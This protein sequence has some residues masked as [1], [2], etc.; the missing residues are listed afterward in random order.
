MKYL[1]YIFSLSTL[2]ASCEQGD[3]IEDKKAALVEKQQALATLEMEIS[4]LKQELA[5]EN[6]PPPKARK[7]VTVLQAVKQNFNRFITIQGNIEPNEIAI[8]TP[9][10]PGRIVS[11]AVNEGDYVQKGSLIA[12]IDMEQVEKQIAEIENSLRFAKD[13]YNRQ[14]RLWD[15]QIGSE[16][17]FLQ[18]KNQVESLEKSLESVRFQQT[19]A[20]VYAPISGYIDMV[21]QKPGELASPGM[22]IVQILDSRQVKIVAEVP[23]RYIGKV[24]RGD[25]LHVRFPAL[26]STLK[27]RV[28]LVGKTIN[29]N[30]RS[31]K[32]E[33]KLTNPNGT[34]K[35]NLMAEVLISD[36]EAKD[37]VV[38]PLELVQQEVGGK[39]YVMTVVTEG[40]DG[41]IAKKVMVETGESYDGSIVI[42][43]G[44]T[45]GETLVASGARG[46]AD[47]ELIKF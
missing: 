29:P 34:F 41:K 40:Q 35:P 43:K 1:L 16:I 6:P 21:N 27:A 11:C 12:T 17:Q 9:E 4:N 38:L 23:D 20:K 15:Q 37:V 44:L 19:K 3:T 45:G 5:T 18:A 10:V 8:V 31:F 24:N 42:T 46:L 47:G 26:D 39:Q 2:V 33:L 36:Y 22:P 14:K 30:N 28:A 25:L 7:A 13:V 32:A